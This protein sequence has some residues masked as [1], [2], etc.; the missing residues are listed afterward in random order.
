MTDARGHLGVHRSEVLAVLARR[1]ARRLGRRTRG[2]AMAVNLTPMI[3]V[4]FLLLIFFLVTTSFEPPEGLLASRLP[5]DAGEPAVA[6]PISPIVVR[7]AQTGAG[8]ADY[9]ISVDRFHDAPQ[10]FDRL[11]VYLEGIQSKPGFDRDTPVIIKAG[12]DVRWDYVV[13]CWNAVLRARF[14]HIAFSAS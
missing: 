9:T 7:V 11:A 10:D 4:T 3:D 6:L 8:P 1:R 12:D 14:R 5:K 2:V 13:N